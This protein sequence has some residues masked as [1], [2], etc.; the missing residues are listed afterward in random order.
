MLAST[1]QLNFYKICSVV[2]FASI[3][4][5]PVRSK[6]DVDTDVQVFKNEPIGWVLY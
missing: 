4:I 1:S 5:D 2:L 3:S 6:K